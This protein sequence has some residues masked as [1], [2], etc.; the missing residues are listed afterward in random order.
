MHDRRMATDADYRR[1]YVATQEA[2]YQI[3]KQQLEDERNN[4]TST[5]PVVVHVMHL[6]GTA[7]GTNE[8][9]SDAQIQAGI[10]HLNDAFRNIGSYAGGPY[11]TNAGIPSVD[12]EIQ[13]CLASRDPNGNSTTGI[14]RVSTSMSNL[15]SDDIVSGST[16]QDDALKALSFWNSNNYMNV[17]LVNEIC[18]L[19]PSTGC[20]TAGYAYLAG[21]HGQTYD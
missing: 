19:A 10:Q 17:W 8:N 3:V 9:I 11:F 6:S 18:S 20:G 2:V 12:V 21:A 16:T 4:K 13:F 15:F 7:V 14:N 5:I 1:R